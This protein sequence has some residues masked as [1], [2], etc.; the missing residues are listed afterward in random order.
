VRHCHRGA[1]A[2]SLPRFIATALVHCA[3]GENVVSGRLSNP[4]ETPEG[5]KYVAA[6]TD[7]S[8]I[9]NGQLVADARDD[10][11]PRLV[12][13]AADTTIE[14]AHA[15]ADMAAKQLQEL[16]ARLVRQGLDISLRSLQAWADLARRLGAIT[17]DSPV[18]ATMVSLAYDL[19]EKLLT[20][21]REVV[22]ELVDNQYQF[23]QRF[24]DT[25]IDDDLTRR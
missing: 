17:P 2:C 3:D 7:S 14:Q 4:S 19:F 12:D 15:A 24:F 6:K 11:G 22:K 16:M 5:Y 1:F 21:Q 18:I 20:T 13:D 8:R 9:R 23:A 25:T 10:P